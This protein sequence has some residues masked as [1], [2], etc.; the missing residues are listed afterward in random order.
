MAP[1]GE[2]VIDR[3]SVSGVVH[4]PTPFLSC[5]RPCRALRDTLFTVPPRYGLRGANGV[6]AGNRADRAGRDRD[7]DRLA[8][9]QLADVGDP[10][11]A[12]SVIEHG[13]TRDGDSTSCLRVVR[14]HQAQRGRIGDP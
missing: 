1:F 8:R 3:L 7:D 5:N 10:R 6:L 13:P 2:A 4:C 9:L 11:S 14:P 12:R